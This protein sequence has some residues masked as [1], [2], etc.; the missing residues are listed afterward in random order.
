MLE[1]NRLTVAVFYRIESGPNSFLYSSAA[2]F[3]VHE[4][5]R[6]IATEPTFLEA[7][8]IAVQIQSHAMKNV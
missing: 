7:A 8:S 3:F 1:N 6:M 2:I 4:P 5:M